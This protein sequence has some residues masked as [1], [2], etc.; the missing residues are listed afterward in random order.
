MVGTGIAISRRGISPSIASKPRCQRCATTAHNSITPIKLVRLVALDLLASSTFAVPP[1]KQ[2]ADLSPALMRI[3]AA[4]SMT[5]R[6]AS[7]WT[8]RSIGGAETHG[9][10]NTVGPHT[11]PRAPRCSHKGVTMQGAMETRPEPVTLR[12]ASSRFLDLVAL[13]HAVVRRSCRAD[14]RDA[15]HPCRR[16]T[17]DR[18][19]AV[20][21]R[22][23]YGSDRRTRTDDDTIPVARR[24]CLRP[25]IISWRTV[26]ADCARRR[27]DRLVVGPTGSVWS[28][29]S[30]P[31]EIS[32]GYPGNHPDDTRSSPGPLV[33]GPAGPRERVKA[34]GISTGLNGPA[35]CWSVLA[36]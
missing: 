10:R 7:S 32:T 31:L 23:Q 26:P 36:S 9:A 6:A 27:P 13:R 5:V 12:H 33:P 3:R 28:P 11:R 15:P 35:P 8:Q 20:S 17:L 14:C 18:L 22:A 24:G 34:V 25:H 19:A 16:E 29:D 4:G 21:A 30:A 1:P 2:Y